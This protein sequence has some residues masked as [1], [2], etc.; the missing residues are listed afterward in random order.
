MLAQFV[1]FAELLV[2]EYQRRA[3]I[4]EHAG[5]LVVVRIATRQTVVVDKDLQLALAQRWAVEM[6][7]VIDGSA[8]CV[9]RRLVNQMNIAK[10]RGIA[11]DITRRSAAKRLKNGMR[12]GRCCAAIAAISTRKPGGRVGRFAEDAMCGRG[13]PLSCT[14]VRSHIV[15]CRHHANLLSSGGAGH[16]EA[17]P[18]NAAGWPQPSRHHIREG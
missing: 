12:D 5:Q 4:P 15:N 7:Q 1:G 10:Q 6:R 11:R 2:V 8:C 14:S 13:D 16:L 17:A 3:D 18:H 9:H